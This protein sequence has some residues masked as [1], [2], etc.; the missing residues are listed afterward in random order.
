MY[1]FVGDCD[2]ETRCVVIKLKIPVRSFGITF[3]DIV[4]Q[5]VADLDIK[6]WE[7]FRYWAIR[8][9][10]CQ[11]VIVHLAGMGNDRDLMRL[12]NGVDLLCSGNAAHPVGII[13]QNANRA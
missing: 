4:E 9:G 7:V 8:I 1:V 12:G 3:E 2:P 6:D 10:H 5:L 13:L 11:V